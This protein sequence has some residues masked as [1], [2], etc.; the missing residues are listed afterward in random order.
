L[1]N[2]L[3]VLFGTILEVAIVL[4]VT[5]SLAT[6]MRPML[7]FIA[8]VSVFLIGHW[9]QEIEF[10][11]SKTKNE[12]YIGVSQIAKWL[13]PNLYQFNW[14]SV[15]FLENGVSAQQVV[16]AGFHAFSWILFVITVATFVFRRKD[17]V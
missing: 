11:G 17:L 13:F 16:W 10:F 14:R 1:Q 3:T 9:T 2:Y 5:F 4:S 6:F 8:G 12:I 7:A 15:Y